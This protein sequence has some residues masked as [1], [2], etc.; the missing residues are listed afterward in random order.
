MQR[1]E[2]QQ[3][4]ANRVLREEHDEFLRGLSGGNPLPPAELHERRNY[5][6]NREKR[7]AYARLRE[8]AARDLAMAE[9]REVA[10]QDLAR[11]QEEMP[12]TYHPTD[13]VDREGFINFDDNL[14]REHDKRVLGKRK[15]EDTLLK[16]MAID[17]GNAIARE[18]KKDFRES[19]APPVKPFQLPT[20]ANNK[21]G[22]YYFLG[23]DSIPNKVRYKLKR[24]LRKERIPFN[25]LEGEPGFDFIMASK[26]YKPKKINKKGE[27]QASQ[28]S[29]MDVSFDLPP[30]YKPKRL[31]NKKIENKGRVGR[32]TGRKVPS[33]PKPPPKKEKTVAQAPPMDIVPDET[34]VSSKKMPRKKGTT[35]AKK[36]TRRR[37]YRRRGGRYYSS[38]SGR[39]IS[40][41]WSTLVGYGGYKQKYNKLLAEHERDCY[42]SFGGRVGGFLGD[43]GQKLFTH[44]TGL[45]AYNIR[46]NSLMGTD[47]PMIRN[48]PGGEEVIIRHREYLG[49]LNSG[50]LSG[51]VT[52]FDLNYYA[53]NP[54][55]SKLFPFLAN[56]A[57]NYQEWEMRGMV[58][59]LKSLSSEFASNSVMGSYFV[60]T[61]YNALSPPPQSKRELENLEYSTSSKPSES[62]LH[63]VECAR[64]L[65]VDTHLYVAVDSNYENGDPR[66][67]D[68]GNLFIGSQGL[69]VPNAP[70]AEVWVSYECALFKPQ[71]QAPITKTWL[72]QNRGV[73]M[74]PTFPWALAPSQQL[75]PQPG[76]YGAIT[77]G[78]D[79]L[80]SQRL[81]FNFPAI[82][83]TYIVAFYQTTDT[84]D[85]AVV[86]NGETPGVTETPTIFQPG[87]G[88]SFNAGNF[89]SEAGGQK[90]FTTMISVDPR[91]IT[92]QGI[93]YSIKW[94]GTAFTPDDNNGYVIVISSWN[95]KIIPK[96]S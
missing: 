30:V 23:V 37:N 50:P 90:Q 94:A 21:T 48:T 75:V 83:A 73:A 41:P 36:T 78:V 33:Y 6:R 42:D 89:I 58:I 53:I 71:L 59:E 10:R 66:F 22:D 60:G 65:N 57:A 64:H 40:T 34:G 8:A 88:G 67:F 45:G 79:P 32:V 46:Q 16:Q 61:Q 19:Q 39:V 56:I 68:L 15:R 93:K 27:S 92:D 86:T 96:T 82:E 44:L 29:N 2:T 77:A 76:S 85:T 1:R 87:L 5:E 62:I 51:A 63:G 52:A 55:N 72:A 26:G 84:A 38:R 24:R 18:I 43:Q 91:L 11:L 13:F 54:G 25:V 47:P 95:P 81:V 12:S 20:N 35:T 9:E 74:T 31:I 4:R 3:E 17:E 28:P 69:N 7:G 14:A 70:I 80:D 49:D